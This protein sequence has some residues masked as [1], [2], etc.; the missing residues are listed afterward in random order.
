MLTDSVGAYRVGSSCRTAKVMGVGSRLGVMH[1]AACAPLGVSWVSVLISVFWERGSLG[2]GWRGGV[3]LQMFQRLV[4]LVSSG[5]PIFSVG[6]DV[7]GQHVYWLDWVG[8]VGGW[9]ARF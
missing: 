3:S 1:V 5:R 2:G 9:L 4:C 7:E 8:Q 6:F